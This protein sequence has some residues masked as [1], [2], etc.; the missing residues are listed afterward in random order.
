[1]LL[2]VPVV[3]YGLFRYLYVIHRLNLGGDPTEV[4][5]EDQPLQV[6][7]GVWVAMVVVLLYVVG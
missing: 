7:I 1:M 5:F 6:S 3:Y 2:T 4:L